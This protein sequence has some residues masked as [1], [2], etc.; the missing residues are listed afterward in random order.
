MYSDKN[1][2]RAQGRGLQSNGVSAAEDTGSYVLDM[3]KIGDVV[4]YVYAKNTRYG[5]NTKPR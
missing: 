1:V 3:G 2:Y 5:P 4:R